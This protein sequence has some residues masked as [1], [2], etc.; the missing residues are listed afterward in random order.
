MVMDNSPDWGMNGNS[1]TN[2]AVGGSGWQIL[3]VNH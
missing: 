3:K 2:Q 1:L